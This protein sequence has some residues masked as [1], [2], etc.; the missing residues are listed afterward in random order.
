MDAER[1]P[2]I[3]AIGEVIARPG[4]GGLEPLAL[5]AEAALIADGG[6]LAKIDSVDVV[7]QRSWRYSDTARRLCDRLGI[8]PARAIYGPYGGESPVRMLDEAA[9]RIE[10]GESAVALIVSG[11]AQYSAGKGAT[12]GWT[13]AAEAEENAF[14]PTEVIDP[15]MFAQG[16]L[17]PAQVYPLFEN[18]WVAARGQAPT[19]GIAESA[20]LWA[21]YAG[22]AAGNPLAWTRVAPSAAAIAD[23]SGANRF[24]AWP[25]TRA[26]VAN[27]NVDQAAAVIVM[28]VAAARH[29]GLR[30]DDLVHIGGSAFASEPRN[31]LR[32]ARFDR[33]PAQDAVLRAMAGEYDLNEIY[34]CF[35]VV[36]KMAGATLG[37]R[38]L[39]RPTMAGGLSFFGGPLNGYMLHA[40]TAMVRA[41]RRGDGATGLLYGQGEFVTKHHALALGRAPLAGVSRDVQAEADAAR[42]P[43]PALARDAT[44]PATLETF[45]VVFDRQG[46]PQFGAVVAG[47]NGWRTLARSEDADT[48]AR[49]L[50]R[51][52]SPVGANGVLA[53]DD[54][55]R[56][57]WRFA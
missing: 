8:A 57:V 48:I 24:I 22:V 33:S 26:M 17:A 42:G 39:E 38:V 9:R 50:D 40:A 32:R 29:A 25:Y 56:P 53:L 19:E 30:D 46:A 34:S 45:T 3:A 20:A 37:E 36:P 18:A 28:S 55:G 41:L 6:L 7:H 11:E 43:V 51:E 2:V 1:Q 35:P 10:R 27:P 16:V 21:R 15:L 5:M 52:L 14:D 13:A 31:W 12:A 47:G 49:L 54:A 23:A 4:E 44:G